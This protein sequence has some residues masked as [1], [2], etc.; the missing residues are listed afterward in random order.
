MT[1]SSELE[2]T[3]TRAPTLYDL[4]AREW[5]A[6]SPVGALLFNADGSA[7]A[8]GLEDGSVALARLEDG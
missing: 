6:G 1:G 7:V 2:E 3:L 4:L 5:G 8:A